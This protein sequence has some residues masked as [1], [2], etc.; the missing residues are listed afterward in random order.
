MDNNLKTGLTI[1]ILIGCLVG[2]FICVMLYAFGAYDDIIMDKPAVIV[3]ILG[4]MIFGAICMGTQTPSLPFGV[5]LIKVGNH[6]TQKV[7]VRSK[8]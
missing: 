5:Y 8:K 2:G 6:K 1:K 3:Q 4:S 7:A